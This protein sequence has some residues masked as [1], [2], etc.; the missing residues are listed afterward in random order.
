M[1]RKSM[2]GTILNN[3]NTDGRTIGSVTAAIIASQNGAN[4]VRVHDILETK[5]AF[6]VLQSVTGA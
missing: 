2:I 6:K 3:R 4:I 5:D 1:S